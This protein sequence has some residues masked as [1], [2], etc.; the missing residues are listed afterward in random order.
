MNKK[1]ESLLYLVGHELTAH[2]CGH[3]RQYNQ[4]LNSQTR[5]WKGF[6]STGATHRQQEEYTV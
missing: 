6:P 3:I 4:R 5:R 2:S 1:V